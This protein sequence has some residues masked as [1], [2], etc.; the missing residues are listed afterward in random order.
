MIEGRSRVNLTPM[1]FRTNG[2]ADHLGGGNFPGGDDKL[3][4][5][6]T[7]ERFASFGGVSSA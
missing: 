1:P 7:E 3:E 4:V 2:P 6:A 5:C